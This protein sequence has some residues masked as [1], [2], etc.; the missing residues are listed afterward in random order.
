MG[1]SLEESGD[2]P[3]P[4]A[5]DPSGAAEFIDKT[6]QKWDVKTFNSKF[7]P[8]KGGFSLSKDLGKIESEINAGENVIVDTK[9]LSPD[10]LSQLRDAVNDQPWRDNVKW[11]P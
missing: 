10:H 2:L 4:I 11:F 3:G 5:R 8:E 6:G 1:L 9:D 7:P